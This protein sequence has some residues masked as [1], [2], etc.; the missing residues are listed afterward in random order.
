VLETWI[1]FFLLLAESVVA[2]A[3]AAMFKLLT[4]SVITSIAAYTVFL[5][6]EKP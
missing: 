1:R 4:P 2:A 3:A 5:D 6:R